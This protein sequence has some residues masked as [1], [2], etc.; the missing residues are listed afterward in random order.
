MGQEGMQ[1]SPC[2][3]K[4]SSVSPYLI[5]QALQGRWGALP[6]LYL[7]QH[8]HATAEEHTLPGHGAQGGYKY[9]FLA[10]AVKQGFL[11]H[12][13][14]NV[15]QGTVLPRAERSQAGWQAAKTLARETKSN[16]TEASF[17]SPVQHGEQRRAQSSTSHW[18]VGI[19]ASENSYD[20]GCF[21]PL[22]LPSQPCSLQGNKEQQH[23]AMET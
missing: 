10:Q 18:A 11:L 20:R 21:L 6:P 13:K 2:R 9:L 7:V 16:Q 22:T 14:A 19:Q 8:S 23:T 17:S 5:L 1:L 4:G 15:D 3:K 12:P